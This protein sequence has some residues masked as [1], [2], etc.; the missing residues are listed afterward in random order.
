MCVRDG[1]ESSLLKGKM[2]SMEVNIEDACELW[3]REEE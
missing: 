1:G 3:R 2:E